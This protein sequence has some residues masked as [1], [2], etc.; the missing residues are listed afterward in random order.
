MM[1]DTVG[2]NKE[3]C[4]HSLFNIAALMSVRVF[5][6]DDNGLLPVYCR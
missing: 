5:G 6:A 3:R 1:M 4:A 2:E